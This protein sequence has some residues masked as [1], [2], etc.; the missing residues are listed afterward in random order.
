MILDFQHILSNGIT[1]L[2]SGTTGA[3]KKYFQSPDK[4]NFANLV[5]IESQKI[6]KASRIY[7]CC[8]TSH[9]G[10][11]LAQ[12]IPALSIGAHVDIEDF[13][14]YN[15]IKKINYYTHSHIT[16]LHAKA[17]MLTKGF[18][19]LNLTGIT[20]TCGADPI[21]WNIV[22]S[23]V[24]KGATFICNW[25]MSEIGPIAINVTFDNIEKVKEY[26][27]LTNNYSTILGDTFW[28]DY[29][30][31]NEQLYVRGDISIFGN[32]WYATNDIVSN[33][34]NVLFYH[35]RKNKTIDLSVSVKG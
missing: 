2:S 33:T 26:Q 12:T 24:M 15:F 17:I 30:I 13:N 7:T 6:S 3:P 10:G 32:D 21:S 1:I 27:S 23:F 34:N 22:E 35:G 20:I 16:P 19:N 4:I 29:S 5:A 18:N 9:A 31:K 14:A 28:C 11:L 25:G 8:K